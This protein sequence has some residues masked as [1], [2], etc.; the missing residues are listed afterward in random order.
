MQDKSQDVRELRAQ[1]QAL[2]RQY[3]KI[4]ADAAAYGK[5]Q[6]DRQLTAHLLESVCYRYGKKLLLYASFGDEPD[7]FSLAARALA[8]GREI[9]F[10]RS[11]D[12]G[13]MRFFRV[14]AIDELTVGRFGI[15]EPREDAEEYLPS[16]DGAD[17]CLVPGL[18]FDAHGFRIG[19]GKGYYDRFLSKFAGVAVGFVYADCLYDGS[20]PREKRYDKHVDILV[21]EKGV[22]TVVGQQKV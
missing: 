6:L 14:H 12:G 2:R 19:Y 8:D 1:K 4:R 15:R 17:I 10:P 5:E 7:T 13:V 18:C 21:C 11:Y 22:M 16:S 3:R 20:L 9:Y